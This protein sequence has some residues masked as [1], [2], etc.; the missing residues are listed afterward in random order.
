MTPFVTLI[1]KMRWK[2]NEAPQEVKIAQCVLTNQTQRTRFLFSVR[3]PH[4]LALDVSILNFSFPVLRKFSQLLDI[5]N[6]Y[7]HN[8][9][10]LLNI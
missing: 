5:N 8:E 4:F 7:H 9:F 2:N 1:G 10:R 3:L 6:F